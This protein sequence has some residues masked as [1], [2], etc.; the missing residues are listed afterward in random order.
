MASFRPL[1]TVTYSHSTPSWLMKPANTKLEP[2]APEV[3]QA[4]AIIK[5]WAKLK[6]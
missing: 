6:L 4:F 5:H 2:A 1:T 3:R